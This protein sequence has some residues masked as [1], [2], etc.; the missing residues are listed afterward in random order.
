MPGVATA[1][2]VTIA[3]HDLGGAGP[4]LLLAHATGFHGRVW[5]P[6]ASHLTDRHA[7]APDLRGH[8]DSVIPDGTGAWRMVAHHASPVSDSAET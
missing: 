3:V 5:G 2:G 7:V 4:D 6:C 8:G 1:D